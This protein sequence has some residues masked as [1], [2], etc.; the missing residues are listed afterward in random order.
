MG[1]DMC[2]SVNDSMI[3]YIDRH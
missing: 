2:A 1:L 3:N